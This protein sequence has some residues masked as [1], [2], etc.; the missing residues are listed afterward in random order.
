[1]ISQGVAQLNVP[2]ARAAYGARGAGLTV[3]VISDSFASATTS[4]EGGPLASNVEGDET[5]N[6][7]PGGGS[8]CSGQQVP[9]E[10]DRRSAGE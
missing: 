2:A 8:T 9:V 10:R 7:L 3:G 5:T 6:D 1:M 4:V